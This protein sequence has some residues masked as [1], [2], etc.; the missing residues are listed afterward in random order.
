M[1]GVVAK[2]VAS[3][4]RRFP[5]LRFYNFKC[6]RNFNISFF[7]SLILFPLFLGNCQDED[8]TTDSSY[9]LTLSV[10]TL[11]FDTIFSESLTAMQRIMVY[12]NN[13]KSIR[14]DKI[15]HESSVK[16][17]Q[18]NVNGKSGSTF[19]GVELAAKDSH[20]VLNREGDA[21]VGVLSQGLANL[22]LLHRLHGVSF[23]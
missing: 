10:D 5:T 21:P 15:Y 1:W 7:L 18:I 2:D 12:N 13:N 22:V 11:S 23:L 16:C 3:F 4:S 9:K 14:I 17:F 6:M 19:N 8:F 20:A